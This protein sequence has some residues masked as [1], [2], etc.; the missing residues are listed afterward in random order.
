MQRSSMSQLSRDQEARKNRQTVKCI[1][2]QKEYYPGLSDDNNRP[3]DKNGKLIRISM[4][5][6][7][8]HCSKICEK[9][10]WKKNNV[11]HK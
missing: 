1:V 10:Y 6:I 7:Q 2:C 8:N 4:A 3:R 9:E 11:K 5:D